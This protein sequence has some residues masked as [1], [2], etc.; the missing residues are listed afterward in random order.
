MKINIKLYVYRLGLLE[1]NH[2]KRQ[3]KVKI[4]L[5]IRTVSTNV[6]D[7]DIEMLRVW[8]ACTVNSMRI[9][10]FIYSM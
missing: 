3:S 2:D 6:L 5:C 8:A 10:R 1:N 7:V 4:S 9:V